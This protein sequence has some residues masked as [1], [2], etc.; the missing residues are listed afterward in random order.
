MDVSVAYALFPTADA[1]PR[2][3]RTLDGLVR[4]IHADRRGGSIECVDDQLTLTDDRRLNVVSVYRVD[5]GSRVGLIGHAYVDG[6]GATAL[7]RALAK[8]RPDRGPERLAPQRRA[9]TA[10][11]SAH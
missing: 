11:L 2:E 9:S 10:C 5:D 8:A 3:H 4:Q 6:R 1:A 7:Q